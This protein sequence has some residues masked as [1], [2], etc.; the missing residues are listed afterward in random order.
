MPPITWAGIVVGAA[1]LVFLFL[2]WQRR[3]TLRVTTDFLEHM[4]ERY[5]TS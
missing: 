1:A 4:H 3:R 5:R 2:H